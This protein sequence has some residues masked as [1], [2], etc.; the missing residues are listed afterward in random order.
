M[1]TKKISLALTSLTFSYMFYEQTAGINFLIFTLVVISTMLIVRPALLNNKT[2]LIAVS[3]SILSALMIIWQHTMLAIIANG[4]SLVLLIGLSNHSQSSVYV[5][6]YKGIGTLMM[7]FFKVLFEGFDKYI[8]HQS[9]KQKSSFSISKSAAFYVFPLLITLVFYFLYASANPVFQ[10]YFYFS[11]DIISGKYLLFLGLGIFLSFGFYYQFFSESLTEWDVAQPNALV[12]VK[13]KVKRH[14]QLTILKM[15]NTK[16]IISLTMLNLLILFFNIVDFSTMFSNQALPNG[17]NYS[18][19]VHQGVNTLIFSSLLAVSLILYYFRANQN[20]YTNNQWLQRLSY[21]WLL[22]NT[23]LLTGVIFKNQLYITEFGLT[24]KRI[25]VYVFLILSMAGIITTFWK[26]QHRKTLWFLFRTNTWFAYSLLVL[27]SFINWDNAIA[28]YNIHTAKQL[29]VTYLLNLSDNTLPETKSLLSNS[30]V[31]L[32]TNVY[33]YT[34]LK[35]DNH[36]S[37]TPIISQRAFILL[38]LKR[39]E[40]NYKAKQW[41]SWNYADE[42]IFKQISK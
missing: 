28:Q 27:S 2:W 8:F 7:S 39:F 16:G 5:G 23:I 40:D 42:Q 21:L 37:S 30:K 18:E 32:N 38:A 29:D 13:R 14:F 9:A 41:Q 36:A 11:L 33:N 22:Q 25:G 15:E 34:H 12:R 31:N 20:F 10:S 6:L 3:G 24:Y 1:D 19:Y 35:N 17:V 4:F 26:V